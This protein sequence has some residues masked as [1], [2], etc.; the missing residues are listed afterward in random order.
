MVNINSLSAEIRGLEDELDRKYE[1]QGKLLIAEHDGTVHVFDAATIQKHKKM[2][3]PVMRYRFNLPQRVKL[4]FPFVY[5]MIVPL[6]FLDLCVIVFHAVCFR[7][8][9]ASLVR[10]SNY[11]VVDRQHLSYLNGLEKLNCV[12]CG[13]ANGVLAFTREVAA[14]TEEYWCPIK[15]ASKTEDAHRRYNIFIQYGDADAWQGKSKYPDFW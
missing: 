14:R 4:T 2:R 10:R 15:H 11:V 7:A 3:A 1:E 8:W 12:F 6:V 5:G 9:R 13:Y